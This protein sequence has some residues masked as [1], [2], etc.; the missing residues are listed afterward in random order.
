ML[1]KV[2]YVLWQVRWCVWYIQYTWYNGTWYIYHYIKVSI[3][4]FVDN[5]VITALEAPPQPGSPWWKI[6][7]ISLYWVLLVLI[8][9]SLERGVHRGGQGVAQAGP[10]H[11]L[12]GRHWGHPHS[13]WS[14]QV[15]TWITGVSQQSQDG[16]ILLK[17]GIWGHFWGR[18]LRY[19][20]N[21]KGFGGSL[22]FPA[23]GGG[24]YRDFL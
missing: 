11:H 1:A 6:L 17:I 2:E 8:L 9:V 14:A 7:L 24:K 21:F 20:V 22:R 3:I 12:V 5:P 19:F 15:C 10:V 18:F 4:M 13:L 16:D 23:S